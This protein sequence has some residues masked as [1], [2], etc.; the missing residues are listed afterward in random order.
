[1][2]VQVRD[3]LPT[4]LP[5]VDHHSVTALR[6]AFNS[7]HLPASS[8]SSTCTSIIM[9]CETPSFVEFSLCLSRACLGKMFVFTYKWLH[10]V[11]RTHAWHARMQQS[12]RSFKVPSSLSRLR[13]ITMAVA[14]AVGLGGLLLHLA[15]FINLPSVAVSLTVLAERDDR[16]RFGT[17]RTLMPPTQ[18]NTDNSTSHI[19]LKPN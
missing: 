14:V 5:I 17:T 1:M 10:G 16:R 6:K 9:L 4:R 18:T 7:R 2:Q 15:A 19:D 13:A 11:R 3:C 12:F 8:K